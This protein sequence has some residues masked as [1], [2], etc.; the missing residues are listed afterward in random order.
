M[1]GVGIFLVLVLAGLWVSAPPN[2]ISQGKK[3]SEHLEGLKHPIPAA[4][5]VTRWEMEAYSER[6]K[7]TGAVLRELG[8]GCVP[9]IR[10]YLKA[11][12]AWR[13]KLAD[14]LEKAGLPTF[15]L[16]VNRQEI[17]CLAAR[18]IPELTG[19]LIMDVY[20]CRTNADPMVAM[21]ARNAFS[22]MLEHESGREEWIRHHPPSLPELLQGLTNGSFGDSIFSATLF[23]V[24]AR[25]NLLP[26]TEEVV[27]ML[28]EAKEKSPH[29]ERFGGR[30]AGGPIQNYHL[31]QC[32]AALDSDHTLRHILTLESGA[33]ADRV[34]AAWALGNARE[35]PVRVVPL[36]M[37]NLG[38]GNLSLVENCVI[39][40]G[41]YGAEARGALPVLSNLLGHPKPGIR[42]AA[43]NAMVRIGGGAGSN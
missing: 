43:S 23:R 11:P 39:A 20:A 36:L 14:V 15:D 4:T 8:P 33:E 22:I 13:G 42:E 21:Q 26:R 38:S 16:R 2:P 29:S 25:E 27:R 24:Y 1:I 7:V 32:I 12:A 19:G 35:R 18:Q 17:G 41:E 28:L 34:G 3:L 30:G 40:L 6:V 31:D 37:T 5:A 9:L 10:E